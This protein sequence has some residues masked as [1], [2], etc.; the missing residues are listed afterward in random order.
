M[1]ISLAWA[2]LVAQMVKNPPVMPETWVLFLVEKIPWRRERLPPP[3]FWP[4]ELHGPYSPWG[5][6]ELDPTE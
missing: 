1:S 2:S 5:R 3:V 4:E 6:K